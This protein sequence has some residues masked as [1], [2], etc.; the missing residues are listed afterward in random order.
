MPPR[1]G[2][3]TDCHS[4]MLHP[5]QARSAAT[6][7]TTTARGTAHV[8]PRY[9]IALAELSQSSA[10]HLLNREGSEFIAS[11]PSDYRVARGLRAR[12]ADDRSGGAL[13][14]GQRRSALRHHNKDVP[15]KNCAGEATICDGQPAKVV[16]RGARGTVNT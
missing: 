4:G 2:G 5:R 10:A 16:S 13:A 15:L 1:L 12:H 7:P 14:D 8:L 3:G 9:R 6:T 11:N